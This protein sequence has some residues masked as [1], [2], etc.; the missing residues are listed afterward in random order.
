MSKLAILGASGHGRIVADIAES[1]GWRQIDFFDDAWPKV[2]KNACW[3]INGSIDDFH[4]HSAE[5]Q[6]VIVGIG[7]NKTRLSI[8]H[9]LLAN[10]MPLISLIHP[11]AVIS[12]HASIGL[13]VVVMPQVVINAGA[14]IGNGVILNTSCSIDHDCTLEDGVHIS[15]GAHLAGG[16]VVGKS[17]WVGIGA[18]VR[19]YISVGNN[20]IVGAGA[21]VVT[22]V[23]S[24]VT[25]VGTPAKPLICV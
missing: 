15:P 24:N 4:M 22:N 9:E 10:K 5:Y 17:T 12:R 13:G 11:S 23:A 19:Q 14:K 18:N 7:D 16:V 6:G 21:T 25:V 20:T 1:C 2:I 8:I 3:A